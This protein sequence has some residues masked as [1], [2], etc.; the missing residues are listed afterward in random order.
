MHLHPV[1]PHAVLAQVPSPQHAVALAAWARERALARDVVP[2]AETVLFDGVAD[3]D[4]LA[5]TLA[6]W[7]PEL[8]QPGPEVEIARDLR[9]PRPRDGGAAT[10]ACAVDDVVARHTATELVVGV[11][12]LRPGFRLLS[13][14]PTDCRA[15][16]RHAA[17]PGPGR[18][19]G[20]GRTWCGVYPV[21]SPGGWQVVGHTD[22]V[23]WDSDPDQPALLAPGTRVRFV[24]A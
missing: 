8:A 6:D 23:L 22:A 18:L 15:P 12:R 13:G 14:L 2:G 16:A 24:A 1:G 5:G 11:L 17:H 7:R 10:G 4:G 9:R 3:P 21:G 20:A 19:G